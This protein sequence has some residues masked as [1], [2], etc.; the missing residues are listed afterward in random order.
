M[1]FWVGIRV[2]EV[3]VVRVFGTTPNNNL[4]RGKQILLFKAHIYLTTTIKQQL[5]KLIE[6]MPDGE[7]LIVSKQG[8]K[9][10][11]KNLVNVDNHILTDINQDDDKKLVDGINS[12][13]NQDI[14]A[15]TNTTT[16]E[17]MD[18]DNQL[19]EMEMK[20]K[21][22]IKPLKICLTNCLIN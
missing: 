11:N 21:E 18:E 16:P 5:W 3:G 12:N 15:N 9:N 22:Q 14:K 6:K 1:G 13:L 2:T 4:L 19:Q 8:L 17:I 7:E 20:Y 10:N